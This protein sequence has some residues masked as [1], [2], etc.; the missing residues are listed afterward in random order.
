[1]T[2]VVYLLLII[3][4]LRNASKNLYELAGGLDQIVQNSQP[5]PEK[6]TTI[7]GALGQIL[8]GLLS[9]NGN[10][11]AAAQLLKG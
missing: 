2:L 5:L 1:L 11:A 4:A 9:V 7:N 10:L 3:K 8:T 6:L